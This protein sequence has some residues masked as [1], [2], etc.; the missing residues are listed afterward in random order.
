MRS[1]IATAR[2]C[3][4]SGVERPID[5]SSSMSTSLDSSRPFSSMPCPKQAF[6]EQPTNLHSFVFRRPLEQNELE[7]SHSFRSSS[8]SARPCPKSLQLFRDHAL[9]QNHRTLFLRTR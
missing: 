4:T 1:K 5:S 7:W 9:S 2:S 6:V 8:F 3:S